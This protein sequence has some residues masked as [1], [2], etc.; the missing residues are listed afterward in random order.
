MPALR[1]WQVKVADGELSRLL[2][3]CQRVKNIFNFREGI[4]A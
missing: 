4:A 1:G 3:R 2:I